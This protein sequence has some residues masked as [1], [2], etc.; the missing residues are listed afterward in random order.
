MRKAIVKS[1]ILLV[2]VF[3]NQLVFA[4]S[5]PN[6]NYTPAVNQ[7]SIHSAQLNLNQIN[8]KE[9]PQKTQ[10]KWYQRIAIKLLNKKFMVA[11][12]KTLA[13][14][15]AIFVSPL[16]WLW[17]GLV[18]DWDKAWWICLLLCLLFFLPG[19]IYGLIK[20]IKSS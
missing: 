4:G 8:L 17:V 13:I 6:F 18:T 3:V 14:I 7:S 9:K 19:W 11:M 1:V 15:L 16:I 10:L 12:G 20:I 2:M 5:V